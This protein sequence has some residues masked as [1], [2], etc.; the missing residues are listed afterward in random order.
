MPVT[1][2]LGALGCLGQGNMKPYRYCKFSKV[3][4]TRRDPVSVDISLHDILNTLVQGKEITSDLCELAPPETFLDEAIYFADMDDVC[5]RLHR[6]YLTAKAQYQKLVRENGQDDPMAEMAQD[7]LES[8]HSARE[9]RILELKQNSEIMEKLAYVRR[10]EEE[11]VQEKRTEEK[12]RHA[13]A[14]FY[15]L[16]L[17]RQISQRQSAQSH[18][19]AWLFMLWVVL[20]MYPFAA[21][22]PS[23]SSAFNRK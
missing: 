23:F 11:I 12:R 8:A 18:H 9:T 17:S 6:E 2:V 3:D 5:A 13:L 15:R 4:G 14:V 7:H 10:Q 20:G 1:Q 16:E 22:T 19:E 21:L